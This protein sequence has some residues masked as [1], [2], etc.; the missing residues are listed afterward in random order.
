MTNG[1]IRPQTVSSQG[2]HLDAG[3]G[4]GQRPAHTNEAASEIHASPSAT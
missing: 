2:P 4:F 1:V 3:R